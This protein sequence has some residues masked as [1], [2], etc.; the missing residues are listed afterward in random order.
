[1]F[2]F[3]VCVCSFRLVPFFFTCSFPHSD[4]HFGVKTNHQSKVNFQREQPVFYL[5]IE[6]CSFTLSSVF[7]MNILLPHTLA[8]KHIPNKMQSTTC[9]KTSHTLYTSRLDQKQLK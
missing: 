4:K 2:S 5:R 8:H 6:S 1:M 9:G 7:L 3:R